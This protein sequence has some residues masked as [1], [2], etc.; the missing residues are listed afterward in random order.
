MKIYLLGR[1][2]RHICGQPRT[3]RHNPTIKATPAVPAACPTGGRLAGSH[4][5]SRSWGKR[6]CRSADPQVATVQR[7]RLP[8]LI[9]RV[10]LPSPALVTFDQAGGLA[11][12]L[13]MTLGIFVDPLCAIGVPLLASLL[14]PACWSQRCLQP[15]RQW[16]VMPTLRPG[17]VRT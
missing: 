13:R 15:S 10:R 4:G 17:S 3:S 14:L 11:P 9:V 6:G 1:R 8:E 12:P 2:D 16:A 5:L 7:H